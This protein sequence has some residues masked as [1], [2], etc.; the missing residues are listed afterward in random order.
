[1][2]QAKGSA[3]ELRLGYETTFGTTP[4]TPATFKLPI[5]TIDLKATQAL[6]EAAT[7]TG[8]R[9]A[10]KPFLGYKTVDGTVTVPVDA[11]AFGYW[12]KLLFGAPTT[13]GTGPYTHVYKVG[14]S[15]PSAFIEKAHTDISQYYVDNGVKANTLEITFGGDDELTASIGLIGASETQD[16]TEVA[17][18][19][20]VSLTRLAKFQTSLTGAT[21]V[22]NLT[23]SF[24]NNLDGDQYTIDTGSTRG[25]I[26]EG[27]ASVSGSM[28]ILYENDTWQ[29]IARNQ[30]E[31]SIVITVDDGT[32][33]L[34]FQIAELVLEPT[35]VAVEG[36]LGIIQ[37]FNY[38]A[39]YDNHA[40]AS[41]LKATLVNSTA[42]Y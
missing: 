5:N 22:K 14:S 25:D 16:V 7:I 21:K 39:Y 33:S 17:T 40:D 13:T 20:A 42:S 10:T 1:M 30:T 38:R 26:P 11:T 2:A 15:T 24:T 28:E 23:M 32:N 6:N 29:A 4:G 9:N 3:F 35:G 27:L 12:L 37:S 41:V 36:P 8:D 34:E 19:T 31:Q 18:P